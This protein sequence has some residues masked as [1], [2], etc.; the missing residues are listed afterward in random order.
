MKEWEACEETMIDLKTLTIPARVLQLNRSKH[1]EGQDGKY[2]GKPIRSR[3]VY[4]P[5][6]VIQVK[7]DDERESMG[8]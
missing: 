7:P 1:L 5:E 8:E 4:L 2:D 6:K 3:F